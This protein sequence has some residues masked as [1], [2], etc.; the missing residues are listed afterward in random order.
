MRIDLAG[1]P[2]H[3]MAAGGAWVPDA[4][5]ILVADL[6][7]GK[8]ATFRAAGH[9]VPAGTSGETLDRLSRVVSAAPSA[10][11]MWILGDLFHAPTGV[12]PELASAWHGWRTAHPGLRVGLIPGNHDRPLVE[13]ARDWALDVPEEEVRV[14]GIRLAH[15]PPDAPSDPVA[16][17]HLHPVIRLRDGRRRTL[18][19]PCFWVRGTTLILPALG[20]LVDGMGI[21]PGGGDRV[22]V[23][24]GDQ[25]LEIPSAQLPSS[26]RAG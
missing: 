20:A 12:T 6:H 22:F 23:P 9:A 3:L 1:A 26:D 10:G 4:G 24:A 17:G 5:A 2:V 21:R 25:V 11:T 19:S 14:G 8:G 13:V 15:H 7:L 18:R 16:A